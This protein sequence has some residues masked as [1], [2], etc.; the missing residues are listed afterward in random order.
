MSNDARISPKLTITVTEAAKLLKVS[1][2]AAYRAVAVGEIPAIRVG[3]R[4]LIPVARLNKLLG[5]KV[6]NNDPDE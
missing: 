1:R 5:I 3:R 6:V 4:I 2:N